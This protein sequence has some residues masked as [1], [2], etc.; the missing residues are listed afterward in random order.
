MWRSEVDPE[1]FPHSLSQP[2]DLANLASLFAP[3]SFSGC[4][5]LGLQASH[6]TQTA[7]PT[8]LRT[9]VQA[10]TLAWWVLHPPSLPGLLCR[11]LQETTRTL[12][13]QDLV[14]LCPGGDTRCSFHSRGVLRLL[15]LSAVNHSSVCSVCFLVN[16]LYRSTSQIFW[17]LASQWFSHR[18]WALPVTIP[19][20]RLRWHGNQA[21]QS[22]LRG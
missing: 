2:G 20:Q 10:L 12:S 13:S 4:W 19:W 7:F 15:L 5:E 6:H 8:A 21:Q 16:L 22:R 1:C 9:W 14:D 11:T 18:C 3:G 17:I